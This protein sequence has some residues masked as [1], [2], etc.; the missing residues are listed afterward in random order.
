MVCAMLSLE[1][2][3]KFFKQHP[4]LHQLVIYYIFHLLVP[5]PFPVNETQMCVPKKNTTCLICEKKINVANDL[6]NNCFPA[7]YVNK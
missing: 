7:S 1:N 3:L 5:M 6:N 4:S 2:I